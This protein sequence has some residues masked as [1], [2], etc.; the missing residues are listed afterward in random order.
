MQFPK[1]KLEKREKVPNWL[2]LSLPF[3][4]IGISFIFSSIIILI[5]GKNPI[6]SIYSIFYGALGTRLGIMETLVKATPLFLTGVAVAIAF[7]AKFWNIGAEGQF[8]AGALAATWAGINHFN[9]PSILYIPLLLILG[10]AAGSLWAII[11]GFLKAKLKVDDVVTTL[12]MNYIMIYFVTALLEGP[13]RDPI[14][15]W[16]QS[17]L[18][19]TNAEFP[20]LFARSRVHLGLIIGLLV[21]LAVYI[22]IKHTKLGFNIRAVGANPT[23]SNFLGINV[24]R[25]IIIASLISGGIAGLAGVGE[26]AGVHYKLTENIS[27]GYGYTGIVVAM[28]A[29]LNPIG[30]IFSSIFFAVIIT[31]ANYMSRATGVT[32]FIADVIQGITLIVFLAVLI[33]YEYRLRRIK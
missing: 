32:S 5:A 14:T 7:K 26:V 33:F 20:K 31:G 23:A 3:I 6:T 11:P 1:Y 12:L 29:G 9:L 18:I 2:K 25:T 16:P 8:F 21:I 24:T 17:I 13:W 15:Q 30:V 4:A 22:I 10:F 19:S 28:F 27:S